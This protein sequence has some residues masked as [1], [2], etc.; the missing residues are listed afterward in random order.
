MGL[1][2]LTRSALYAAESFSITA[3]RATMFKPAP[4][5]A[6][7]SPHAAL[8]SASLATDIATSI[9][10]SMSCRRERR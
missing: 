8:T 9:I 3:L 7:R 1:A 10:R 5:M 6:G 2:Q 4:R